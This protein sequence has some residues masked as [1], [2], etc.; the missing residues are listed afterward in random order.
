MRQASV[1]PGTLTPT[2]LNLRPS[3]RERRRPTVALTSVRAS[4]GFSG[5]SKS[6]SARVSPHGVASP[7]C[8]RRTPR[9]TPTKKS[10]SPLKE[11]ADAGR[12]R[13]R[14]APGVGCIVSSRTT[15]DA[16][17][18]LKVSVTVL[19]LTPRRR[20]SSAREV[21]CAARRSL[22]SMSAA[23]VRPGCST[24]AALL[25]GASA[26]SVATSLVVGIY[27]PAIL[28]RQYA[29]RSLPQ[30]N[31]YT[32]RKTKRLRERIYPRNR[33]KLHEEKHTKVRV[34]S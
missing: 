17:R 28:I 27:V 14:A 9:L 2:N 12:P 13:T 10:L 23:L 31:S 7:T 33:T 8:V 30:F 3:A 6:S 11:S 29:A 1:G 24:A 21:G 15:P 18:G 32:N 4:A 26:A 20:A 25:V 34:F 22:R 5:V 19:R 16:I